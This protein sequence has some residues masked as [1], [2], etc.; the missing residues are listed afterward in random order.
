M[1]ENFAGRVWPALASRFESFEFQNFEGT[2][3]AP[4]RTG[5]ESGAWRVML[6]APDR[7]AFVFLRGSRTEAGVWR[8]IIDADD[9]ADFT[10]LEPAAK[11]MFQTAA[12]S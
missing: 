3:Q 6:T 5:D 12:G 4:E 7:R 8:M 11:E 9:P 2:Q 10:L 1:E